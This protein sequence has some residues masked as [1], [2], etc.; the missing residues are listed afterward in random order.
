[1]NDNDDLIISLAIDRTQRAKYRAQMA[2]P[3]RRSRFLDRLNHNPT[4]DPR[5]TTWFSGLTAALERVDVSDDRTVYIVS[6]NGDLDGRIMTFER[7]IESVRRSG[8]GAIIL[9]SSN[10]AVYYG[11][12]GER[13]A[14]VCKR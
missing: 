2:D 4:L 14:L 10:L 12:T 9:I 11:E 7:A 13:A 5:Y 1:M 3:Q 8:W 6:A